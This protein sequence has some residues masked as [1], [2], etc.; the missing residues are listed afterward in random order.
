MNTTG[1][2]HAALAVAAGLAAINAAPVA[3]ADASSWS[4]DSRSAM[5]LISGARGADSHE[6]RAGIEIKL[7]AEWKTYWRY[8]GDAG[9]PPRFD[10]ARSDNVK[11]VKVL[12]PAPHRLSDESG[13]SI[14]YKGGVIFPLVVTPAN[15]AKPVTLRLKL[16]YAVCE[17]ICIPAEGSAEL[18]LTG[19]A[20]ERDAALADA[21]ARVP[22]PMKLGET[23]KLDEQSSLSIRSVKRENGAGGKPR[24]VVDVTAPANAALDLFAEGP[25][26][27]WALPLPEPVSGAPAGTHRFAFALDGLPPGSSANG[28]VLKLTATAGGRAIEVTTRLD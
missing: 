20:S 18:A 2:R 28:A 8:P 12:W 10:F 21:E 24:V 26:A 6:L 3:A 14:G 17:K 19:G 5:R 23:L 7:G 4:S 11:S 1:L 27:E 9:V 16:D 13:M 25:S 15:P 22:K